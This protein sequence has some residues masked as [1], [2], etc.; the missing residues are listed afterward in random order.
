MELLKGWNGVQEVEAQQTVHGAL[1][2]E[3]VT[4]YR[5][6]SNAMAKTSDQ[7]DRNDRQVL[8][9]AGCDEGDTTPCLRWIA[10]DRNCDLR[11][12]DRSGCS[13]IQ[14]HSDGIHALGAF[15]QGVN[16]E[17]RNQAAGRGRGRRLEGKSIARWEVVIR[18]GD[19][20]KS[21]P[22]QHGVVD[23]IPM[24]GMSQE[25]ATP[26]C[27]RSGVHLIDG[28]QQPLP[29]ES[30]PDLADG[31]TFHGIFSIAHGLT[32]GPR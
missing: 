30:L 32:H 4:R 19:Q 7:G 28:D 10:A 23:L 21:L 24:G 9:P 18:I 14:Q 17:D 8:R 13:S 6:G 1:G 29:M 2:W 26:R 27:H 11:R 20:G 31:Y 16:D 15:E 22:A 25:A 5:H 3:I 12:D